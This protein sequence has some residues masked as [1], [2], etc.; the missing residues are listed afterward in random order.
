MPMDR[1]KY[2]PNWDEI[3]T[4]VKESAGWRCELCRM[5]CRRPG[6]KHTTHK[7]TLT[8]AHLN[9]VEMD[10]RPENLAAMCAPCHL[11]YDNVRRRLQRAVAKRLK[12]TKIEPLF[13]GAA[14]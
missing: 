11:R 13:T 9:H 12:R 10:V 7:I 8:V 2:P 14:K 4:A 3:A 5:Q 6:E 1:S